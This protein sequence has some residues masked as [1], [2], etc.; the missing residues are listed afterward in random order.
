MP[1]KAGGEGY[2]GTGVPIENGAMPGI[3]DTHWRQSVFGDEVMTPYVTGD[4]QPLSRI[5]LE[6]LYE[7]GYE[8]DVMM[9]DPF[10]LT[11]ARSARPRGPKMYLGMDLAAYRGPIATIRAEGVVKKK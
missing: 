3:S 7:V 10:T 1:T 11:G 6:A 5:T 8:L 9:A 4:S 2:A